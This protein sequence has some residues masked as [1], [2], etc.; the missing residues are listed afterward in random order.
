WKSFLEP[1]KYLKGR[2]T[3]YAFSTALFSAF[4]SV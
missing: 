2:T 1:L 3:T 4:Y